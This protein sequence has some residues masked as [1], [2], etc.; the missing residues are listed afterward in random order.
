MK[1]VFIILLILAVIGVLGSFVFYRNSLKAMSDED[2]KVLVEIEDK[3]SMDDI[4][5]LLKE[6]DLIHNDFTFKVYCKLKNKKSIKA[7][8]Y[9]LNKNMDVEK[10]VSIL[11]GGEVADET[12]TITF[13]EGK[14]I[15]WIA[16]KIAETT[17]NTEE[18][19]YDLLKDEEYIDSLI[20][21]YSFINNDI[22]N[23]DIYYSLEG[24]LFP[25]TYTFEDED[26]SVKTIF[27]LMLNKMESVL[28]E[29]EMEI[30]KSKYSTH[31][32]LTLASIVELEG[33]SSEDRSKIARVFYNRLEKEN[34]PLQS[35]VTTYYALNLD[36]GDRDLNDDDLETDNPY[37][38]G[39]YETAGELPVGPICSPGKSAID[40]VINPSDD[41]EV[42]DAL[43]F[44]ADKNGKVYFNETN[45]GH[46]KTVE[47]LK[48]KGLWYEYE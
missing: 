29:Y 11:E 16:K 32:L 5:K 8:K 6:K 36:L 39:S 30:S 26:V 27:E 19:V 38:T 22:K 18:D 35:D 17:N 21:K 34:M 10:I 3:S 45:A 24:Y 9:E 31:E 44:A 23:E 14:N 20:S 48:D 1:K 41:E 12:V 37:N 15:T 4:A 25:D 46:N 43:Y 40:A 2:E 7:G 42:E 13:L 33:K 47:E 28:Q